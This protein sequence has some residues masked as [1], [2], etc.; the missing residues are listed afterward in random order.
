MHRFSL[1]MFYFLL[2]KL[3]KSNSS[4]FVLQQLNL[5]MFVLKFNN[6]KDICKKLQLVMQLICFVSH[7]YVLVLLLV[8]SQPVG[9]ILWFHPWLSDAVYACVALNW[10][11]WIYC[12]LSELH[13]IY[14]LSFPSL[15]KSKML[16]MLIA[17]FHF[18]LSI[19]LSFM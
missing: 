17:N 19:Y 9:W 11:A 10:R 13:M 2:L 3:L 15:L 8:L 5:N 1:K 18:I 16:L 12:V 4:I 14:Q 6:L 7:T